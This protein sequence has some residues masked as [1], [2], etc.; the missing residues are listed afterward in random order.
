[1][2]DSIPRL[3][4][5]GSLVTRLV[6]LRQPMPADV[7]ARARV[8]ALS[9]EGSKDRVIVRRRRVRRGLLAGVVAVVLGANAAAAYF[10]PVYAGVIGKVPGVG[11][12]LSL[13][14]LGATD[15]TVINAT[16]QHDGVQLTVVAGYA[17]ENGTILTV[18]MA[19][20]GYS[21]AGATA[22]WSLTDQFGHRYETHFS[23]FGD[24]RT[25][26]HS[27]SDGSTP[28]FVTFA[29]VTGAAAVAGARLALQADGW[30]AFPATAAAAGTPG[31]SVHGTWQV[32]FTLLRHPAAH[33][34]WSPA[35]IGGLH[36]TFPNTTITASKLVEIQWT[37][38]GPAVA[39]SLAAQSALSPGGRAGAGCQNGCPTAASADP[40]SDVRQ[41]W[42]ELL[43][44]AGHVVEQTPF[45]GGPFWVEEGDTES[46]T[47]Q[48]VLGTG[49]Y[50][51]VVHAADG[52]SLQRELT[53]P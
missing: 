44:S 5:V 52:S 25:A 20:P 9:G 49:Q 7:V 11:S 18:S 17:D 14:G 16:D 48:Y 37:A 35:T 33:V 1:V 46:G 50:H 26:T 40:L 12:I 45:I 22:N 27:A 13:T 21:G 43:D 19:R 36:Y 47:L 42:P 30:T 38:S 41:T 31:S 4:A 32:T 24:K 10:V 28:G 3:D 8:A 6:G 23:G 51:L 29:P 34:S 39:R 53:I 2:T 15:V